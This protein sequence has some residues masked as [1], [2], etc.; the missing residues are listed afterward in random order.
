MGRREYSRPELRRLSSDDPRVVA[1]KRE[2]CERLIQCD[3]HGSEP[4]QRTV[5]CNKCGRVYQVVREAEAFVPICPAARRAPERCDCGAKLAGGSAVP[6][7][8]GCF[9]ELAAAGG[10]P[11]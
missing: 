1:F 7:C 4:W 6:I 3:D 5:M 8:S 9:A 10:G 2:L 11:L